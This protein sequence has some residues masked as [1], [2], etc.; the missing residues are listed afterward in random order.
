MVYIDSNIFVFASLDYDKLSDLSQKI[1]SQIEQRKCIVFTSVLTYDEVVWNI[2]KHLSKEASFIAGELF[3]SLSNLIVKDVTK[4]TIFEAHHLM[5]QYFLK[6]RDA[7]HLAT[8]I[9]ENETEILS[10]DSDFDKIPTIKRIS[11]AEFC[12]KNRL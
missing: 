2:R 7:I 1:I 6:P 3:L 10:E 9:L 5:K 11:I 12:R 4:N 8:M